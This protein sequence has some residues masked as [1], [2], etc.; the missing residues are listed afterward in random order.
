VWATTDHLVV[1]DRLGSSVEGGLEQLRAEEGARAILGVR[2]RR[3][4]VE[5][6]EECGSGELRYEVK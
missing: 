6:E 3:E 5:C 1:G 4:I 2:R